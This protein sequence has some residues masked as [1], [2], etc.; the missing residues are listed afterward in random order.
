MLVDI[1]SDSD[2]SACRVKLDP[3]AFPL[4]L[5]AAAWGG[6]APDVQAPS[7]RG[8]LDVGALVVREQRASSLVRDAVL[9][10]AGV[11]V[12]TADAVAEDEAEGRAGRARGLIRAPGRRVGDGSPRARACAHGPFVD[13]VDPAGSDGQLDGEAGGFVGSGRA[14]MSDSAAC[15]A[16]ARVGSRPGF[17]LASAVLARFHVSYCNAYFVDIPQNGWG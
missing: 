4:A 8:D 15:R 5:E 13:V 9:V 2:V 3:L 12:D 17:E 6:G 14:V 16:K 7:G 1:A 10:E 11:Q